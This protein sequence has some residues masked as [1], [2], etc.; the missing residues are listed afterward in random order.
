MCKTFA[1]A[2]LSLGL[3]CA[4]LLTMQVTPMHSLLM[5]GTNELTACMSPCATA[6][7]LWAFNTQHGFWLAPL[8]WSNWSNVPVCVM[9]SKMESKMEL[10]KQG[11]SLH[12]C[13]ELFFRPGGCQRG[14]RVG[15]RKPAKLGLK[16]GSWLYKPTPACMNMFESL[17]YC[18]QCKYW[19]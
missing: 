2:L 13:N 16:L 3:S 11:S 17:L 18:L 6:S 1:F 4:K 14:G 9:E 8:Y 15:S 7:G 10:T 19:R 5:T 12:L